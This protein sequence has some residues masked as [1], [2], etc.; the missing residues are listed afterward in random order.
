MMWRC[1]VIEDD[2]ENARY[3]ADSLRAQGHVAIIAHEASDAL[4]RACAERWDVVILDRMLGPQIDGLNI[5]HSMRSLGLRTPVL[6]LSALSALDERVRGL[7]AGGDDYLTKPFAF[8]E[9]FA[10]LEAL[11]R[12]TRTGEETK[13]LALADLQ[14]DLVHR[15]VLRNGRAI[16]LKPREFRLLAYLMMHAEQALTRTM[17]LEAVWD[18]RFDP[19]TNLIDV[20]ISRLR[21]KL[22]APGETPLIHT[23]RGVGYRIGLSPDE[24]A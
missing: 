22:Q 24:N 12:R 7:K 18:Y 10:R 14:L 21:Q 8:S 5:L 13:V 9:L 3:I 17:L 16:A 15:T 4:R 20:Q 1:L 11:V 6:V 2:L 19:Q 23:V